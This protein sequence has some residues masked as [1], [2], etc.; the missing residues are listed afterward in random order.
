[1]IAQISSY[2]GNQPSQ[3][4]VKA[5]NSDSF[6][7]QIEEWVYLDG[8]HNIEDVSYLVVEAGRHRLQDGTILEAGT[9]TVNLNWMTV[10]FSGAF[11]GTPVVLSQCMTRNGGD[12]VVTRQRNITGAGFDLRLQEEE[13]R[14]PA[15]HVDET[16]GYVALHK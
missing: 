6:D 3:I 5:V 13:A 8:K 14:D 16:L 11:A 7:F 15:G 4:R 9:G 12:P 10:G 1:M 2:N